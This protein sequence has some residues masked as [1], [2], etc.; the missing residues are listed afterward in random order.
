LVGSSG[1]LPVMQLRRRRNYLFIYFAV[2]YCFYN[3]LFVQRVVHYSNSVWKYD[4]FFNE[5]IYAYR[6]LHP[7]EHQPKASLLKLEAQVAA[8][9]SPPPLRP[10]PASL[11]NTT[12]NRVI[13]R[14]PS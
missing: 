2:R 6:S 11:A 14:V 8:V 3:Y 12:R 7:S 13:I 4:L 9:T 10:R 5:I 1:A